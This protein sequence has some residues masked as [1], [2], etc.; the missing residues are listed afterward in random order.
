ML[1]CDDYQDRLWKRNQKNISIAVF[2]RAMN[3]VNKECDM[4]AHSKKNVRIN[5]SLRS[6]QTAT[7]MSNLKRD[8]NDL[9]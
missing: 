8:E 7:E 4:F 1:H 2:N 5:F 6:D 9:F 3:S